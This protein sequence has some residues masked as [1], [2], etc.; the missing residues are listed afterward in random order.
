MSAPGYLMHDEGFDEHSGS[1]NKG[2]A[3]LV[4]FA[5]LPSM[6]L[7]WHDSMGVRIV[8]LHARMC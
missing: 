8:K 5:Y 6:L 7:L 1:C 3:V 2:N 4:L